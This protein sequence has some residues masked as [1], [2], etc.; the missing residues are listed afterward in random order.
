MAECDRHQDDS[1]ATGHGYVWSLRVLAG[2]TVAVLAVAIATWTVNASPAAPPPAPP[3]K[4]LTVFIGAHCLSCHDATTKKGGLDLTALSP[5]ANDPK[6]FATWVKVHDRVAAGEMPPKSIK[7]RPN[8]KEIAAALD[9]LAAKLVAAERT[10]NGTAGRATFRRLTRTEYEYTIQD[11]FGFNGMPL[12]D[13][14]PADGT[15]AGF[16]KVGEALDISHVQVAKYL[17]AAR[18]TLD[19]AI[20]TRAAAPT[21]YK[22]R[23][24]PGDEYPFFVGLT[25]GDCVL[26]KDKKRDPAWPLLDHQLPSDKVHYYIESVLRPSKGAVGVFRHTDDSFN[27]GFHQFSPLLPGRYKLR[28]S[29][30]SF[31]WDKGEVKPSKRTQVVGIRTA[32]GLVGCFDAPSME[33]KVHE[34]EVWL[35]P[36]DLLLFNTD[37]LEN[38]HVYNLKGRAK[39][40]QGPGIAVDWLDVEGPIHDTW[41]PPAHKLLFGNMPLKKLSLNPNAGPVQA[42]PLRT[43]LLRDR[44]RNSTYPQG[45]HDHGKLDG[46]WAVTSGDPLADAKKLLKP[47]LTR[48][49]RRP[50]T[51]AQVE[52]FTELVRVR[53]TAGDA[54]EDAMRMAFTAALCSPEFLFRVEKGGRLDDYE[55]ASRLSFFLWCSL[56]DDE[57][58]D[59]ARRG[60][61]KKGGDTLRNQVRRMLKDPRSDR[62]VE[63]FLGQWLSLHDI[64]STTPDRQLYPD[65]KPYLQDCMIGETHAFFRQLLDY[66]L[67]IANLVDSDF[68]MLNAELGKLYGIADAPAGHKFSRVYLPP[69]THRGGVMTQASVLKVTANGTQTT[70]VKR[71]AWVMD[72]MLG[73]PPEPPPPG[74][75]GIDPDLRGTTTIR[76]QLAKHRDNVSCASCHKKIDPPGFALESYDVIGRW[77]DRYRSKEKGD[78]VKAF[79]GEGH[80]G[81]SYKLALPVDPSG[82]TAD[83][84]AFKDI[85]EFKKLLLRDERQLAKNYLQ[86]L[87]VYATGREVGF[88]DRKAINAIL[89]KCGNVNKTELTNF[90]AYR[91]RSLIE[92]LVVSDLFLAK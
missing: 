82:E 58:L 75:T 42:L 43:P 86:R 71:G 38:V 68:A 61:L 72:R 6:A 66:N 22:R 78:P 67:G 91:M 33:S 90:G 73:T 3:D 60:E 80:Y 15:A 10:R 62:F 74:I 87:T 1:A 51:D 59:L 52:R 77:R 28:L 23:L 8:A 17:D 63:D 81:V 89:D 46:T 30:W 92:E 13:E 36:N 2:A 29:V 9:P 65:F 11:L 18:L 83:G 32:R 69:G 54:F 24:Y 64:A 7:N 21:A 19:R 88:A 27:P 47:F 35:E 39:E 34:I 26:L 44:R 79:V 5:D 41:P 4:A 40:Y 84:V 85:V 57:L 49:F 14:L 56:P 12:K 48:A 16:N 20:A 45:W 25:G 31:W 50:V 37:S 70:P 53:I 55:I 76:Q